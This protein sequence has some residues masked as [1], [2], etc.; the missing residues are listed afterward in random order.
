MSGKIA[1]KW[2]VWHHTEPITPKGKRV[3][4]TGVVPTGF[5]VKINK[6]I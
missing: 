1:S 2:I 6:S 5:W 3:G 4:I